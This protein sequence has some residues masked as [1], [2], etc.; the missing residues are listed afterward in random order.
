VNR[1]YVF[2]N[3]AASADG[4]IDTAERK[5]ATISSP[6]D[7]QR[8]DRLRA[9]SD[10]V[11]VGGRT[12]HDEDP[13]LTVKS[14]ALRAERVSLGLPPNP[15]KVSLSSR[16]ELKGDCRFLNSGPARILLF[17]TSR[18]SAEQLDM[19]RAHQAE[20]DVTPQ[21]AVDLGHVMRTLQDAGVRRLMVEGGA[22]LNF[23]LLR[24]GLVDEL[25]IFV[26]PLIFGGEKAPGLASGPGFARQAALSL[27]LVQSEQWED[28]GVLLRYQLR[29]GN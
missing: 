27:R 19:L 13:R 5:G 2:I 8:V 29:K 21:A 28:E 3:V 9:E 14:E 25:F 4:K 22:T 10:A 16:L 18:T 1:P 26:A 17:T 6:R 12:L 7:R 23:E 11:M 15:A 20:V 24:L